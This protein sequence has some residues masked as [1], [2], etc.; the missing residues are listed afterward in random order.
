M[1]KK[2]FISPQKDNALFLLQ[3]SAE[4][5]KLKGGKFAQDCEKGGGFFKCCIRLDS[6]QL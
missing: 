2:I 6:I 3:C 4:C 5:D 1:K